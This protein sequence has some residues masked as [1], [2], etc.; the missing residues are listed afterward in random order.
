MA[1]QLLQ[2]LANRLVA[3]L[4]WLL[5]LLRP[6]KPFYGVVLDEDGKKRRHLALVGWDGAQIT[7]DSENQVVLPAHWDHTTVQVV[8]RASHEE[9]TRV[10]LVRVD[11]GLTRIVVPRKRSHNRRRGAI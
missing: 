7:P 10:P 3:V 6:G 9:I 11:R 5:T 4:K 2:M 8:D 1:G